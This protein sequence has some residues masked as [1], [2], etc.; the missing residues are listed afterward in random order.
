MS[1]LGSTVKY[2]NDN[3]GSVRHSH[4]VLINE[5]SLINSLPLDL[6]LTTKIDKYGFTLIRGHPKNYVLDI[7]HYS[8]FNYN[9][10][11]FHSI[12]ILLGG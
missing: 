8:I 10:G 1:D 6:L 2:N 9:L 5:V 4:D 7:L 12:V 3:K 11:Y